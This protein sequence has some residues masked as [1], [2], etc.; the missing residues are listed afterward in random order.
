MDLF[1][2]LFGKAVDRRIAA[3][4]NDLMEK[5]IAEV[6]NLY[7][8]M[9]GWRHDYHNHIQAMKAHRAL[10]QNVE[11]DAYLSRLDADLTSVDKLIK[12]GTV[13]ADAILNSKLSLAKA[14][15]IEV[16]AKAAVP[17]YISISEIDL[18][19]IIGNLLDNAIEACLR[20]DDEAGRYIRLYIDV[21]REHL[22]ISITNTSGGA[23][24]KRGGKY[25]S[26]KGENHGFGLLRVDR[27]VE[28]YGGYLRRADESGA[29]S[30]EVMLPL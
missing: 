14:R 11:L 9:R 29:F 3:F 26:G 20:I 15:K 18:C 16:S 13:M 12:S 24:E 6:Q 21:K 2:L 30:T 17:E 25:H 27:I 8:D 4:Q 23:A 19:V 28:K 5:H 22:Y 7:R 1:S 10:G